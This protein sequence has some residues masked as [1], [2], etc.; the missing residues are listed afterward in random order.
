[1]RRFFIIPFLKIL[2]GIAAVLLVLAYVAP[3][4]NPAEVWQFEF[5]ALAFPWL[6]LMNV[7][8]LI[9]WLI[10]QDK[11]GFLSVFVLALGGFHI[12]K[13]LGF[14]YF[15]EKPVVSVAQK[16]KIIRIAT[17]NSLSFTAF[18]LPEKGIFYEPGIGEL[19]HFVGADVFCIQEPPTWSNQLWSII[20]ST[21]GFLYH[22]HIPRTD[23]AIFSKFP[24][25][26]SE[27][28]QI[29]TTENTAISADILIDGRVIRFF[30]LHLQSNQISNTAENLAISNNWQKNNA[31][32]KVVRMLRE[33]KSNTQKRAVQAQYVADYIAKSPYPVVVCGDFNDT[34]QS[35]VYETVSKGMKDTFVEKGRGMGITYAGVIPSLRIDYILTHPSFKIIDNAILKKPYS[36]HYAVTATVEIGN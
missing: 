2:H 33:V 21:G 22:C 34:P 8:F 13:V 4:I 7:T 35:Y 12:E 11:F 16:S 27:K 15:D 17:F 26:K 30:S 29:G 36:D 10:Y 24:I 31:A 32:D 19:N 18:Y 25:L 1:M 23:N 9:F 3:M 6:L 28:L 14:H 5:L 20:C